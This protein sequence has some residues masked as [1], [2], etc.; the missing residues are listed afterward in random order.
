VSEE[1]DTAAVAADE[2]HFRQPEPRYPGRKK[3]R[4]KEAAAAAE[5]LEQQQEKRRSPHSTSTA[6]SSRYHDDTVGHFRG[7]PG[8]VIDGR[9]RVLR[10]VGIGT[11]F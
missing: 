2:Q 1:N 5:V 3:K 7:G 4:K 11:W 8:T 6:A 9:Y 10:D